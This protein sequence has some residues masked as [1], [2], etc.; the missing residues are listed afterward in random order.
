MMPKRFQPT[1]YCARLKRHVLLEPSI[2]AILLEFFR[3]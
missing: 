2:A 3:F 1:R